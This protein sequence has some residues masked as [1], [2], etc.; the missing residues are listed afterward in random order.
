MTPLKAIR[1]KCLDCTCG[2][3]REVRLCSCTD[4]SLYPFR[5]GKNPARAGVGNISN[6]GKKLPTQVS[7]MD[8]EF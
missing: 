3:S 4:C 8:I 2:Q 5:L 6:L 1:S 7:N